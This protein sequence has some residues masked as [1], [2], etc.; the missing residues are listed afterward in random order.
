METSKKF[1]IFQETELSYIFL[2]KVFL[3]FRERYIQNPGI[4]GS[5]NIFRTLAFLELEAYWNPV[6]IRTLAYL[7]L[8]AYSES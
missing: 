6:I 1:F 2:K 5:R 3:I 4:F 7:E 8:D